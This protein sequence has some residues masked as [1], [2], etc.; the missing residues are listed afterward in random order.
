MINSFIF[1]HSVRGEIDKN[2]HSVHCGFHTKE[3]EFFSKEKISSFISE[4]LRVI[5]LLGEKFVFFKSFG[6][7]EPFR[8]F[9]LSVYI[10]VV[11][12]V[13]FPEQFEVR[14]CFKYSRSYEAL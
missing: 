1:I 8:V 3:V 9:T 11:L 12:P 14:F 5:N 2:M 10:H 7:T 6:T 4:I 13:N